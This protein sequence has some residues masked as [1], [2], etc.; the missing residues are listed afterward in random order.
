MTLGVRGGR[1][2]RAGPCVPGQAQLRLGLASA[3]RGSRAGETVQEALDR[4]LA[5]EGG[6]AL[7]GT[8]VLHG[9]FFN[10][11]VSRRDHVAVFVRAR[12]PC[13]RAGR[14]TPTRSSTTDFSRSTRSPPDT[15]RGT[16]ARLAEVFD[17][18]A[19]ARRT[20]V[21]S[22]PALADRSRAASTR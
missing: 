22:P 1:G 16:R 4:E 8:P 13:R 18:A 10:A 2:R 17:G 19:C 9:I 12:L 20:L 6:I 21:E 3:G 15:T 5:E 11:R 14:A 7:L